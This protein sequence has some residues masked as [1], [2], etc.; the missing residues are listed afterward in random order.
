MTSRVWAVRANANTA[1]ARSATDTT[2][3]SPPPRP[4]RR[5]NHTSLC[6][7]VVVNFCQ[8]RTRCGRSW[9]VSEKPNK[10][11]AAR[12]DQPRAPDPQEV[13]PPHQ[14]SS[15]GDART[16]WRGAGRAEDDEPRRICVGP[17]GTGVH[18]SPARCGPSRRCP[19]RASGKPCPSPALTA[20]APRPAR[21]QSCPRAPRPRQ[22]H[23]RSTS[24]TWSMVHSVHDVFTTKQGAALS[25][26]LIPNQLRYPHCASAT[27]N[28]NQCSG[29]C[30]TAGP[31][32][33][34]G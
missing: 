2:F 8:L 32:W 14:H 22:V 30:A 20:C 33:S 1:A 16:L 29:C 12:G 23:R 9:N 13:T 17:P 15:N 21:R 27:A 10:I 34:F 4:A 18:R 19:A 26:A 11:G 31:T 24:P 7:S 6:G 25:F 3:R 5:S 28:L